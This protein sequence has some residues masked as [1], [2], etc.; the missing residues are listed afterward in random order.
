MAKRRELKKTSSIAARMLPV[1][2]LNSILLGSTVLQEL[3]FA[4]LHLQIY[5]LKN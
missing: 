3:T 5:L 4:S 1:C 2:K